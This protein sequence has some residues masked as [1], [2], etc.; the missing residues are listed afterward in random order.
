[1]QP[2][3]TIVVGAG[4]PGLR[5]AALLAEAGQHVAVFDRGTIAAE[6]SALAAGHV[7]QR[8]YTPEVLDILRRTRQIVDDLDLRTAG[9]VRFNVVGGLTM[10]GQPAN[11][12]VLAAHHRD[13]VAWGVESE[14][15]D[16]AEIARRWP[17]IR[18]D[19]LVVGQWAP[20]DGYVR[21]LDLTVALS[22]VARLAGAT[23]AE[24]CP[25][26]RI[27]IGDSRV[28]GAIVA[29]ELVPASRVVL[30]AG[31]WSIGL[32]EA[33]GFAL[34]LRLFTLAVLMLFGNEAALPFLSDI[35]G[36]WYSV[37]RSPGIL[38]LGLPPVVDD[39]DPT[40]FSRSPTPG[41]AGTTLAS[42]RHRVPGAA[43][44]RPVDG[45]AG[46]LVSTPD[47]KS[48][49]GAH[50][51]I[52]GLSLATGFGGGGLQWVGAADAV[53]D[54]ILG[55]DPFFDWSAHRATRFADW[56]PDQGFDFRRDIPNFYDDTMT[57]TPAAT[58]GA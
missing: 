43:T 27:E 2:F 35:D 20:G 19:D 7:P 31:G 18:G 55:R 15:L 21:S 23:L 41:V 49:L 6:S 54:E 4:L 33:S 47:G 28:R 57:E 17:G 45:W 30:A 12:D 3:D 36:H 42:L 52:T 10:S 51:D 56:R 58:G 25:V 53:A 38:L 39:I 44:A 34:P 5:I 9:I 32:A 1:M 14:L 22:G 48:L 46:L 8:A 29:G 37:E 24:G 11:R 50:P 26:Q 13:L 16:G 40:T